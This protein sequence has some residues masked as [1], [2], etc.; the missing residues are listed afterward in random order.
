MSAFEGHRADLDSRVDRQITG[1][2]GV[3]VVDSQDH[4]TSEDHTDSSIDDVESR[5]DQWVGVLSY[6]Y[7]PKQYPERRTRIKT[8][9]SKV[10]TGLYPRPLTEPTTLLYTW[11]FGAI[12]DI[13]LKV[14]RAMKM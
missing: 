8:F 7:R 10:G 11:L 5:D 1:E 12:Q 2:P 6:E 14:D 3:G 13:Q 4:E 9:Q